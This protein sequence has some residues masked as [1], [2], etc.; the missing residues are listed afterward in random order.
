MLLTPMQQAILH[1]IRNHIKEI[2]YPPSV[3][4][5]GEA[6]KLR[7][8]SGVVHHLKA[9]E[10]L[11]FLRRDSTRARAMVVLPPPEQ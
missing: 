11:G 7:S 2:G 1:F 8:K 6:V 9:L 5:I 4:E 10:D 3:A